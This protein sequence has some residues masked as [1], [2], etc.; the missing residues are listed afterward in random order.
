MAYDDKLIAEFK[1]QWFEYFSANL[2]EL[3]NNLNAGAKLEDADKELLSSEL[4]K[5]KATFV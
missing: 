5:F 1:K 2:S 3:E 4:S